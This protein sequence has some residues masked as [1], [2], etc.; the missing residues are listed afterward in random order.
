MPDE[1]GQL[2]K[3]A[4][5]QRVTGGNLVPSTRQATGTGQ[6]VLVVLSSSASTVTLSD[7]PQMEDWLVVGSI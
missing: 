2:R 7:S 4:V 1:L 6:V 5:P 3:I